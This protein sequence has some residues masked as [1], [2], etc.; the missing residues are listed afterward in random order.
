VIVE[1]KK[2]PTHNL[3]LFNDMRYNY[4]SLLLN[5]YTH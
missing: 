2:Y 1:G 5:V 3:R 4:P